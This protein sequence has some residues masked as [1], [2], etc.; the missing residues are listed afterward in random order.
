MSEGWKR[1]LRHLPAL[2][3]VVLLVGAV[4]VVQREFRSL[5]TDDIRR[6]LLA[7]PMHALAASFGWTGRLGG[8]EGVS[9]WIDAL[10]DT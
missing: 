7:I 8:V 5:K 10:P 1:L 9:V 4:Y 3:G 6:A 2:L